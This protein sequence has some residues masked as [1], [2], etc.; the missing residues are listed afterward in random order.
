MIATFVTALLI[1]LAG[2][3]HCL[4]MCG[5]LAALLSING[6]PSIRR[7]V[8]YNLGRV[9][10]YA[11]F[12]LLLV[13]AVQLGAADYY[14]SLMVPLRSLAGGLLILMGLYICGAS[15][16]ILK[17]EALGR[18]G[19]RALHPLAKRM[20]P[21]E[22]SKQAFFAGTLWGWLPCGLVYSTVLWATALGTWSLSMVAI[23]G[24]AC[25]TLPAMLL[26]GFFSQSLKRVWTQYYLHW[27]FGGLLILYGIYSIPYVKAL[28]SSQS[29]HMF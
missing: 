2:A 1:G 6:R 28:L 12:T 25:G 4:G 10:S 18:F 8:F 20:L 13:T 26:A 29:H 11:L 16:W 23:L 14:R 21:I 15:R 22:S 5:G 19:W 9:M 24:F 7:I 17:V 3:G 27:L